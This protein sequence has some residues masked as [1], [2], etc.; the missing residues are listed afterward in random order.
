[1]LAG[2]IA[3]RLGLG[4]VSA[5]SRNNPHYSPRHIIYNCTQ[6][7]KDI[8]IS[9]VKEVVIIILQGTITIIFQITIF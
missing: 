6:T 1:M 7:N 8:I 5:S 3:P 4:F 2:L 9:M